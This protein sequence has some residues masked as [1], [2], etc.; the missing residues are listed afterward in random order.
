ML[1]IFCTDMRQGY[2]YRNKCQL[3]MILSREI[4]LAEVNQKGWNATESVMADVYG[5][6]SY[7]DHTD[8][9]YWYTLKSIM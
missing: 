9:V 4:N 3:I 6:T 5:E 8:M 2:I 1:C 7:G